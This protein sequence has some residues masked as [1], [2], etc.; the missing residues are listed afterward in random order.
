MSAGSCTEVLE[1]FDIASFLGFASLPFSILYSGLAE[2]P[3]C[4]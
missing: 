3:L 1:S 4:G 2:D